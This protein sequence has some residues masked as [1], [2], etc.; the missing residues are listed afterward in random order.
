MIYLHHIHHL[1]IKNNDRSLLSATFFLLTQH[2][3]RIPHRPY[4]PVSSWRKMTRKHRTRTAIAKTQQNQTSNT[5][6]TCTTEATRKMVPNG[7]AVWVPRKCS[8][9]CWMLRRHR[10]RCPC[11]QLRILEGSHKFWRNT[12]G[13][14]K[15]NRVRR[16]PKRSIFPTK[17]R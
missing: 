7:T 2:R 13:K 3:L 5:G 8:F 10:H 1:E 15:P 6:E 12:C 11:L 9:P 16:S 14:S 17:I 4:S